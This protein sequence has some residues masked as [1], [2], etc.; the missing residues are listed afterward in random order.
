MVSSFAYGP[1]MDKVHDTGA[2]RVDF[3]GGVD[4]KVGLSD[5]THVPNKD[6]V[7]ADDAGVDDFIDGE[8]ADI[9]GTGYGPG[10]F[11]TLGRKTLA[12]KTVVYDG[13]NDRVE[14]D[15]ADVTWT[16]IDAG[17]IDHATMLD[18]T[19]ETVDTAVDMVVNINVTDT[20]TNGG[21]ITIQWNAEGILQ[22][23]V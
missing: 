22:L 2:G 12:S 20:V 13:P 23:T 3:L 8:L 21:D 11:N 19:G 5:S 7:F 6:D 15:A 1:A 9:S 17:T 4:I 18:E 16:G 14:W 10:G